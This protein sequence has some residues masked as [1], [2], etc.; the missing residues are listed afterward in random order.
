MT[1]PFGKYQGEEIADIPI[2]YLRWLRD[3]VD[4]FGELA[5]EVWAELEGRR[6]SQHDQK[7]Q[8]REPEPPFPERSSTDMAIQVSAADAPLLR[9]ILERGYKAAARVHHPDAGG[10]VE[11]MQR[12]NALV[13]Y[14]RAQLA[15]LGV[16]S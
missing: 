15:E 13:Q 12:L 4:L 16:A 11:V 9:E 8:Q 14:I 7:R 3:N 10:C 1:M 6:L 5:D 2:G